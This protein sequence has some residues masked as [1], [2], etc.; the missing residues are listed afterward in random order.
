MSWKGAT[1]C[2]ALGALAWAI[3]FWRTRRRFLQSESE[4]RELEAGTQILEQERHVLELIARGASLKQVLDALTLA[5]EKI[6]PGVVCTVLLVDRER[7]CLVQGAAPHLPPELW[8]MCECLPIVDNLGCCP[9]AAFR[10]ATVISEDIG[11]DPRWA[12]VRDQILNL[13]LRSCWSVPIQDSETNQVIGTF[14]MYRKEASKPTPFHLRAVHA[15]S[16]LAG[17]A[18]ERLRSE[19]RLHEYAGRFVL[20]EKAAAFG[21]WE[22]EPSTGMFD[23]SA[24]TAVISG[25]GTAP[26][27]VNLEQLYETVHPEDRESARAAREAAFSD[28]GTYEHEFRRIFPDGSIRWYRNRGQVQLVDGNP[29]KV[30]GAI[31]D[32]TA[33]KELQIGLERAKIAAEEAGRLKSEFLANMSHEIRTPMNGVIGMMQLLM[34]TQLSEEQREYLGMAYDSA[35]GLLVVINDVLDFSKIEAGKMELAQEPFCVRK[36]VNDASQMFAWKAEEKGIR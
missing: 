10:N 32:I 15:G 18:I 4:R 29:T 17:N 35:E 19:Q 31:I 13:G 12:G 11:T 6:V 26:V 22:W 9:T 34:N 21:I 28:G 5:V 1:L 16:Q 30:I 8:K 2:C 36:C 20:A 33:Q 24:S 14:A 25:L 7:N 3:A 27:R 23:C